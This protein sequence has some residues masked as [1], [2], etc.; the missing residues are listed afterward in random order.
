MRSSRM[1]HF[2]KDNGYERI[3]WMEINLE[4]R[5]IGWIEI[6]ERVKRI[7]KVYWTIGRPRLSV[8]VVEGFSSGLL[9]FPR[10][11][12]RSSRRLYWNRTRC[13]SL[14]FQ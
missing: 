6:E 4:V 2:S 12:G 14:R 8:F 11:L 1:R 5:R 3:L 13:W 9:E 10:C 7:E